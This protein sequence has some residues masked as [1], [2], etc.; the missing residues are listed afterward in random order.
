ML[1]PRERRIWDAFVDAMIPPAADGLGPSGLEANVGDRLEVV[2]RSFPPAQARLFPFALWAVEL[3]P[4]ALGPFPKLF[5]QLDRRERTR[6]LERL[7]HHFLYPL[8]QAYIALKLFAFMFW[9]EHPEVARATGWSGR[10]G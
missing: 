6:C 5:T 4:I 9:A 2:L 1:R 10:C 8:R 3:Y 7:E